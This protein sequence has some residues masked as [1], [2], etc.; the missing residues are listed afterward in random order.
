MINEEKRSL[1]IR[2]ITKRKIKKE[3][4]LRAKEDKQKSNEEIETMANHLVA[5]EYC[6]P[7]KEKPKYF[8][9]IIEMDGSIHNRFSDEILC[10]HHAIDVFTGTIAGGY[11]N[12][13]K[14][15]LDNFGIPYSFK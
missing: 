4:L 3:E 8:G 13:Y 12:V 14:Q 11:Y 9:E 1:K 6:H 5:L 7:R 2:R 10:L 15:I